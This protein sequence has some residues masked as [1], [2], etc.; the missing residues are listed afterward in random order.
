MLA[1]LTLSPRAHGDELA[2]ASRARV[3][4]ALTGSMAG[5]SLEHRALS[6]HGIP[7]RGAYQRVFVGADGTERTVAERRPVADPALRPEQARVAV[8]EL[9]AIIAAHRGASADGPGATPAELVYITVLGEPLLAWEVQLPL[10]LSPEPSR[11]RIWV[12]AATGRV[13]DEQEQVL[14][15]RA[16][17]F[18]QNPSATPEPIEVELD[19]DAQGPWVPLVGARLTALNCTSEELT[20]PPPWHDE[21][22]CFPDTGLLSDEDGNYFTELP[23][24]LYPADSVQAADHYAQLSLYYHSQRFFESIEALGIE[25]FICESSLMLANFHALEPSGELPFTP[26]N[27]AFYTNQCDPEK[28]PT[29][30]FGQGSEVDFGYDGDVVYHEL[31]HGLVA[32]LTPAGLAGNRLRADG[33]LVDARGINESIADYVSIL[34]TDDPD[35]GDYIGRFWSSRGSAFIRTAENARTCPEHM[36]GQEHNDGEAFT[37]ALWATRKRV[38]GAVLDPIV[39][40]ALTMMPPDAT[41]EEGSGVVLS[42][43]QRHRSEGLL[44]AD[45]YEV[46]V[47]SLRARGLLDCPRVITDPARVAAG[48]R[49]HLRRVTSGAQPFFPGPLQL[50]YEVPAGV[51]RAFV[52]FRLDPDGSSDPVEALVLVR[53]DDSPVT[54]EYR[55]VAVDEPVEIPEDGSEPD[56]PDPVRE[57]ILTTG[58]WDEELVAVQYAPR[59]FRAELSAVEEGDVVHVTLVN[60]TSTSAIATGLKVVTDVMIDLDEDEADTDTDSPDPAQDGTD[61]VHSTRAVSGGCTCRAGE[62]RGS[63][64]LWLLPVLLGHRRRRVR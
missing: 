54:F 19:I 61:V 14:T 52:E 1:A 46:L 49:L 10:T 12:S 34:V 33:A 62:G 64:V 22:D 9:P 37:A 39:L 32:H 58:D 53:R 26:L 11:V 23:N 30:I 27:N 6:L 17:V 16:R 57:V 28:G 4:V 3:R 42:V 18:A 36:Q 50:R 31:G 40:E 51:T 7:V 38:G 13:L 29:M 24:V 56:D 43:A 45:G 44:D 25:D 59:L 55:L 48:A 15:S 63:A 60:V 5:G 35:L 41:L 2:V 47:R 21:T 20:E 8:G